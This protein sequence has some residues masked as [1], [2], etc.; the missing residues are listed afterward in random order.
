MIDIES[1][2]IKLAIDF[3]KTMGFKW[4]GE[5]I[6]IGKQKNLYMFDTPQR[7]LLNNEE[8]YINFYYI[9]GNTPEC[10]IRN[11]KGNVLS[12]EKD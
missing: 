11:A 10:T 8:K 3:L 2:D 4:N 1:L 5:I 7:V 6:D 9:N 12:L